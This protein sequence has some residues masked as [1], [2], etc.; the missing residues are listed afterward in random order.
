MCCF[1]PTFCFAPLIFL[2]ILY[3]V[4]CFLY[5]LLAVFASFPRSLLVLR[6]TLGFNRRSLPPKAREYCSPFGVSP[7]A[8]LSSKSPP[9]MKAALS[10]LR[11]RRLKSISSIYSFPNPKI[12]HCYLTAFNM[13]DDWRWSIQNLS[14]ELVPQGNGSS[15][16]L[17]CHQNLGDEMRAFV[18]NV[19]HNHS[20]KRHKSHSSPRSFD[21]HLASLALQCW[22]VLTQLIKNNLFKDCIIKVRACGRKWGLQTLQCHPFTS[23]S[24]WFILATCT[25]C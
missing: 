7:R 14:E 16:L 25:L 11:Q 6:F 13:Q 8:F 19:S 24:P 3:I 4:P 12:S 5:L 20:L 2:V 10:V 18:S 23:A 1:A 17:F 9:R 22:H 15:S 21:A